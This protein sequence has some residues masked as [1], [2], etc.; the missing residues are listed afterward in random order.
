MAIR[1]SI[2]KTRSY[3]SMPTQCLDEVAGHVYRNLQRKMF[4]CDVTLHIISVTDFL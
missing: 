4:L 1:T 2:L 3:I